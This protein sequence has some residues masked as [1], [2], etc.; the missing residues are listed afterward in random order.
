APRGAD[1]ADGRDVAAEAVEREVLSPRGAGRAPAQAHRLI[2][3][4]SHVR[5]ED[6]GED[7]G[8]RGQEDFHP[9]PQALAQTN[10][11]PRLRRGSLAIEPR[12]NGGRARGGFKLRAAARGRRAV[13][14]LQAAGGRVWRAGGG[15]GRG[16]SG[17]IP[18]AADVRA[19]R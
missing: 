8:S 10:R 18:S 4:D 11:R 17:T 15:G 12:G 3:L 6:G 5:G 19:D 7:R 2:L 1:G 9:A 13:R 14:A 16:R